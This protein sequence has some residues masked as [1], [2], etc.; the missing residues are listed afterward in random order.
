MKKIRI[1]KDISITMCV[2][3]NGKALPLE[4][5]D[6]ML[7]LVDPLNRKMKIP[8]T[9]EA[10]T[11]EAKIQGTTQR[12]IGKYSLT[13]WENY[14]K[15]GQTAVDACNAFE[16]VAKTCM[17]GG[18]DEGLDTETVELKE[19]IAVGIKGDDGKSAYQVAVDNGFQGTEEEWLASLKG[20]KGDKGEAFTYNNFT[21]EQIAE[22]QRPA[23]EAADSVKKLETELAANEKERI[24]AEQE[25]DT[26]FTQL[27][28]KIQ[29]AVEKSDAAVSNANMAIE[30]ANMAIENVNSA[31][32][33]VDG[34]ITEI[35]KQINNMEA[36]GNALTSDISTGKAIVAEA[37]TKK[38]VPTSATASFEQ[39]AENIGQIYKGAYDESFK[40]IIDDT[41]PSPEVQRIGSAAF[42]NWLE[43][44]IQNVMLKDG[45]INYYLDRTNSRK[46]ANGLAANIDGSD[47]DVMIILPRFWYSIVVTANGM[48]IA[49]SNVTQTSEGWMESPEIYV[50]ASEGVI[51]T[52]GGKD[53]M[54]SCFNMDASF[55]GGNGSNWDTLPKSLLG[56]PRTNK[57]HEAFRTACVNKT[58]L[59]T[60]KYHQFDYRTYV[61]LILMFMA[62]YG[63]R[64]IQDTYAGVDLETGEV[65]RNEDGF[66][67]GGLGRG[68]VDCGSWW[69]SFNGQNPFIHADVSYDLGCMSGIVDY[70][71]NTG[72]EEEP[73][74]QNL[75]VPVLWGIANPYGHIYKAID[76][77]TKQVIE[78]DG[79]KHDRW[80]LFYDPA[81]YV[82]S[83]QEGASEVV[84]IAQVNSGY[85]KKMNRDF[86]PV[87]VGGSESSYWTDQIYSNQTINNYAVFGSGLASSGGSCGLAFV[88]SSDG[89]GYALSVIGGRLCFT[90]S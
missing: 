75:K 32:E 56:M 45:V 79:I 17:E 66:K 15:P 33:E 53:Y 39:M 10:A 55:R 26:T 89:V 64:N 81:T 24:A 63:T 85:I 49:Y 50:G 30:N 14:G 19:D 12:C 77:I 11:L 59:G 46:K 44:S 76:G 78:T 37:I 41:L 87:T 86:L 68:V 90:P 73:A 82:S 70:S 6:L 57:S 83:G 40:V 28:S 54:R 88:H 62:V 72:T 27:E 60:G 21:P 67:Y 48:E 16:L 34:R 35:E 25:R 61:K 31:A 4:G 8:F 29:Q 47:G 9:V 1:G 43:D 23:T 71:L 51:E 74:V 80:A 36:N 13:L 22:L 52:T 2:L 84:D 69:N 7:Q 38:G 58:N 18:T 20:E 5:R 3:T 65:K 42:P